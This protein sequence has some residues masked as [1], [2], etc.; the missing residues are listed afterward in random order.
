MPVRLDKRFDRYITPSGR[1]PL[2]GR[3]DLG[4]GNNSYEGFIK[5]KLA[6]ANFGS[7]VV[8]D[9]LFVGKRGQHWL[10]PLSFG[11]PFLSKFES[12][13]QCRF[14]VDIAGGQRLM[15]KLA[16]SGYINTFADG[17]ELYKCVISGPPELSK[18]YS[19]KSR[20]LDGHAP[21][22]TLYHHTSNSNRQ[23]I[24]RSGVFRPSDWNIQGTEKKLLNIGY[25]YFTPL[26]QIANIDDLNLI[27]MAS[28]GELHLIVDDFQ[29][30]PIATQE[31]IKEDSD[32][33]LRLRVSRASTHDR[34][35]RLTFE[36]ETSLLNSQHLLRHAPKYEP[37][38]YEIIMPFIQ[39]V[40]LQPGA[41][42]RF[43]SHVIMDS[44]VSAK[45]FDYAV[46]GDART[47]DGLA[48]PFNE[49]NTSYIFKFE[50]L[51]K[52][53]GL[54]RF[55]F[56]YGNSDQYSGVNVEMAQFTDS[57]KPEN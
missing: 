34:T 25:V 19:G 35:A 14:S 7:V 11:P 15:V 22:V 32:C 28:D 5:C 18:H 42:L 13:C 48:A 51:Q 9:F 12:E 27:A 3:G 6:H 47:V 55:W 1:V 49:E 23:S 56:K 36:I 24:K 53:S 52:E 41:Q 10:Q 26:P 45:R 33:I 50:Q 38:W 29:P 37:V 43:S 39:R 54:L 20:L 57:A 46:I 4:I 30:P 16:S 21:F 8:P 40:G 2:R 17:S 31:T 44:E